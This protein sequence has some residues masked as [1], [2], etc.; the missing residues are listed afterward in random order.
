MMHAT[1]GARFAGSTLAGTT[2]NDLWLDPMTSRNFSN[3]DASS[4]LPDEGGRWPYETAQWLHGPVCPTHGTVLQPRWITYLSRNRLRSV[5]GFRCVTEGCAICFD[6]KA[7]GVFFCI[8][9]KMERLPPSQAPDV[10]S[11]LLM[12]SCSDSSIAK[13]RRARAR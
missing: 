5:N 1:A 13:A 9:W 8:D 2:T 11:T 7:N 6:P 12:D 4:G 3:T 10:A